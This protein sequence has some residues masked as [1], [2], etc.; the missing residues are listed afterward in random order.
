MARTAIPKTGASTV[1][2]LKV[3]LRDTGSRRSGAAC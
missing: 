2:S 1:V 3:T